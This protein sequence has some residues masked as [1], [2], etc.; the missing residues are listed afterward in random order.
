[1]YTIDVHQNKQQ[2]SAKIRA[3]KEQTNVIS[4]ILSRKTKLLKKR[5][6]FNFAPNGLQRQKEYSFVKA[7]EEKSE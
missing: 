3:A 4:W 6:D 5:F 2:I 1:M 7:T